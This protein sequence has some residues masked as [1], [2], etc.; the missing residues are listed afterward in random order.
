[1]QEM[2]ALM[3]PIRI[4][5]LKEL[6]PR[7]EEI[8]SHSLNRC[9]NKI[10]GNRSFTTLLLCLTSML[11]VLHIGGGASAQNWNNCISI[12]LS[13]RNNLDAIAS[14]RHTFYG[15]MEMRNSC[16]SN[17]WCKVESVFQPARGRRYKDN[18]VWLI[19]AHN[20][21]QWTRLNHWHTNYTFVCSSRRDDVAGYR[22]NEFYPALPHASQM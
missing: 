1:M 7:R 5:Y 15:V 6:A 13:V 17:V 8:T 9:H 16:S 22:F 19:L 11:A 10:T 21:Q 3:R 12:E 20:R 4:D 2:N 18:G 14:Q